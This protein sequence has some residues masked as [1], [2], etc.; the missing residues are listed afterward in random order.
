MCLCK[1]EARHLQKYSWS[2]I[3]FV[4]QSWGQFT[5]LTAVSELYSFGTRDLIKL[6]AHIEVKDTKLPDLAAKDH[7]VKALHTH[8]AVTKVTKRIIMVKQ[9]F[10]RAH[11][12][13][14]HSRKT[15]LIITVIAII[16]VMLG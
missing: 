1:N 11:I 14:L 10:F 12:W 3:W 2:I 13:T 8:T 7:S 4:E 6:S 5:G 9:A 15:Q 16:T